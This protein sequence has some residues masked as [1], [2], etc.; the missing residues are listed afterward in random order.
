MGNPP[1]RPLIYHATDLAIIQL[2]PF[3][4]NAPPLTA[5]EITNRINEVTFNSSMIHEINAIVAVNNVNKYLKDNSATHPSLEEA[6]NLLPVNPVNLYSITNQDYMR[7]LGYASKAVIV[8]EFLEELHREGR[9]AADEWV[10]S[11]SYQS[12]STTAPPAAGFPDDAREKGFPG[13]V[14]DRQLKNII[15]APGKVSLKPSQ[16]KYSE[17]A[18]S[19]K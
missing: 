4:R 5:M 16:A 18:T 12:L 8:K 9:N 13:D 19:V 3:S 17:I 6:L 15:R 11:E 2:N 7:T 10:R 1:L 14:L